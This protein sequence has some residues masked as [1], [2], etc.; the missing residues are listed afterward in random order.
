MSCGLEY[1]ISCLF[2]GDVLA[3]AR[4]GMVIRDQI[5]ILVY[6]RVVCVRYPLKAFLKISFL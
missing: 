3:S 6:K 1:G 5:I 2:N 4:M